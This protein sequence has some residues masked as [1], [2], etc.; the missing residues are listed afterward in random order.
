VGSNSAQRQ[1]QRAGLMSNTL[2]PGVLPLHCCC[3]WSAT[4]TLSVA[5]S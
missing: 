2:V 4:Y 1:E 5:C 3:D